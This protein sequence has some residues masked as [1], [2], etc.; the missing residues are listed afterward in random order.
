MLHTVEYIDRLIKAGQL[1]FRKGVHRKVTYHDPCHL[2]RQG[3]PFVPW[4]GVEKK[5]KSQIVAYEPKKPRY[6]GAWGI[7][8]PP[9]DILESIPGVELVEMERIREYSWCCGA[10]GGVREAYPDFSN[11]TANERITEAKSTG[12]EVLATACPWCQ[13]NFQDAL[14][15]QDE[16]IKIMDIIELVK[17]AL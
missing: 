17:Q 2:G 14:D 16:N 10:G 13:R 4:E 12:A 1:K 8:D 3:E 11:W 7:Y 6:N 9:R 15:G 5:I